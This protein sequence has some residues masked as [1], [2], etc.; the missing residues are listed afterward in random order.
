[1]MALVL[2][3]YYDSW[4]QAAVVAMAS[5]AGLKNPKDLMCQPDHSPSLPFHLM[6]TKIQCVLNAHLNLIYF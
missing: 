1:M 6:I 2:A 3:L 5:P 4:K